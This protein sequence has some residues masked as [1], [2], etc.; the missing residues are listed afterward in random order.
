MHHFLYNHPMILAQ[1]LFLFGVSLLL[2]QNA[3]G[4]Y[5][6]TLPKGVRLAVYRHVQTAEVSSEFTETGR[7]QDL[8][9]SQSL[10]AEDLKNVKGINLYLDEMKRLSPEAYNEFTLGRYDIDAKADV[11]VHGF[12]FAWGITDQLTAYVSLPIYKAQVAMRVQRT[13]GNNYQQVADRLAQSADKS[14]TTDK[15]VEQL[16]R[17][18]PDA[19]GELLQTVLVKEFGYAP[20]GDWQAQGMG[21]MEIA[22]LYRLTNHDW[23]GAATR[24]GFVL[25]T[26][27]EDDP[28]VL[29][30][31]AFGDGQLDLF[32]EIG[33]GVSLLDR[34]LE[35]SAS[36]GYVHQFS[37]EKTYR[38][39][40]GSGF[41][42]SDRKADFQ[43][44][45]GNEVRW[46]LFGAWRAG[47][48][49]KIHM[50]YDYR[51]RGQSEYES[52]WGQINQWLAE[53]T[54]QTEHRLRAGVSL[55]SVVPF[56]RQKFLFPF[57]VNLMAMK[58]VAGEN[59]PK[60]TRFDLEFRLFF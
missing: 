43:E 41:T 53:G 58:T 20:L 32:G 17:Q 29:Q 34:R 16:T 50:G 31:F 38:V 60:L 6:E 36:L 22:A 9:Y 56:Q 27:R 26:G 3:W 15:L 49:V 59:T 51:S 25:P 46:D 10:G 47:E 23:A 19:N 37:S 8:S 33:G 35:L 28:D 40:E 13:Q 39:P 5:Y 18:L 30:D 12:G 24:F 2:T 44:K 55:T 54:A 52:P 21:D 14:S 4:L 7:R 42:I 57:I 45:L 11:K 1:R 48:W